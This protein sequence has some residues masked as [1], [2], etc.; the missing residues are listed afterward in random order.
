MKIQMPGP[1]RNILRTLQAH[2][3]EAYIVGGCVRDAI[4]MKSP[5]DWDI[6]TSALPREVK[7]LFNRTI[8][9]GLKHGTVTIMD[10][11]EGFEVTTFRIDGEYE[12][13]RRPKEVVFTRNLKEDLMRRD[14]TINAM[15]YSEE[16]G[17]VDLFGGMEDLNRRVIRCVGNPEERF[18]EDA[19]RML[20]AVRFSAQ[21]D[22]QVDP[23]TRAAISRLHEL[24]RNVSAE[25]IQM[26]MLKLLISDHPERF[27]LAYE[28]GLTSV[29]L[30]EFD[31]LMDTEQNNPHHAYTVGEHT[32]KAVTLIS[33]NP[34]LRLTMLLHD[35]G[36]P[37]CRTTDLQGI[38]H[39]KGHN[40][41]GADMSGTILRRLKF[42]NETIRIVKVL[43][44]N[45]DI[46]FRN[47]LTS[48]RR[49]VRRVISKVGPSL[50][51]YLL[52]VMQADVS[53]QSDYLREEKLA[54]LAETR[55]AYN[56]ILSEGNC[57]TL[58]DLAVN[59][60]D[61]MNLGIPEGK[62]IGAILKALLGIVLE[63]PE[64][65]DAAYLKR[66]ALEI[67]KEL[68]KAAEG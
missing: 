6:T 26:E 5:S 47:S 31:L 56:R 58:K 27:R 29:F 10:G 68:R 3:H 22:F 32:L 65:N 2:G 64:K 52:D 40:E 16:T 53:A 43:I 9:T 39:F 23:A 36:K 46:R 11:K 45:H 21:L 35:I 38:D 20:R 66:I 59:G 62:T 50:F 34:V 60:R 18:Q 19:L 17:L 55:E 41:L 25:R 67:Y 7:A 37:A 1:V 28:T 48:G 30:P 15:A 61:L 13:Y 54:A 8:D 4:L 49:H 44:A 57:L 14:F 33:N 12:D 51:P 24:I 42:D 63:N